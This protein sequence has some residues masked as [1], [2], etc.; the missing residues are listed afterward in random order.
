MKAAADQRGTKDTY[1]YKYI[2]NH[3]VKLTIRHLRD[4]RLNLNADQE[5]PGYVRNDRNQT[6]VK[7]LQT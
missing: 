3:L 2:P 1:I 4:Q 5:I 6:Y 7:H